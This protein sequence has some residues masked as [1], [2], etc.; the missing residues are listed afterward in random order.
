[1]DSYNL[2]EIYLFISTAFTI[3]MVFVL[4]VSYKGWIYKDKKDIQDPI[5]TIK[6]ALNGPAMELSPLTFSFLASVGTAVF[7]IITGL[8][9]PVTVVKWTAKAL[10]LKKDK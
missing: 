5:S 9:W 6:D 8:A 10:G 1:M 4:I 7:I 2:F 3:R